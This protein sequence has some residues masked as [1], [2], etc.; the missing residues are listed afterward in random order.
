MRDESAR[1]RASVRAGERC[2]IRRQYPLRLTPRFEASPLRT[3]TASDRVLGSPA[4]PGIRFAE[5]RARET[6]AEV[7][8]LVGFV[9][10]ETHHSRPTKRWEVPTHHRSNLP[11]RITSECLS[12]NF[13]FHSPGAGPRWLHNSRGTARWPEV[14]SSATFGARSRWLQNSRGT[15]RWPEVRTTANPPPRCRQRHPGNREGLAGL[16]MSRADT[17]TCPRL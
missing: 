17:R 14:R 6:M 15:A 11:C 9:P 1:H 16:P 3:P 7:L 12:P 4:M 5:V 10:R 2:G 8:A 13:D